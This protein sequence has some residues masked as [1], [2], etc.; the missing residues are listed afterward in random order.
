M[1]DT[2]ADTGS[3]KG[4][5]FEKDTC[6]VCGFEKEHTHTLNKAEAKSAGCLQ[7][8]N[9]EYFTCDSCG[10]VFK[11]DGITETTAEAEVIPALGHSFTDYKSNND[12]TCTDDG[13]KTAKCDRCDV[14]DTVADAGSA[15]GHSFVDDTCSV[16]G[17][18]QEH[19][20]R[21]TKTEAVAA[22]C[23]QNGNQEYWYCADCDSV[24][25]DAEGRYLTNRKNVIIPATKG[26]TY[27]PA[28]EGCHVPGTAEYWYCV[29][30]EAVFA[31]AAGT[32]LTN[33]KNLETAPTCELVHMDAVEPCHNNG[34][35]EY[36]FCPKCEA[37]FADAE[38]RQLTNRMN[39]TVPAVE[40][41]LQHFEAV[42]P[43]KDKDGV[44]EHW[45]C[46][47]CDCYFT[48]AEGKYNVAYKSL[49]LPAIETPKTGDTVM[50]WV[51]LAAVSV[52]GM[53]CT[54]ALNKKK[55]GV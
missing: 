21:M 55:F 11:A 20:H 40:G 17:F 41:A 19:V 22:T 5:C 7:A 4:H 28:A 34:T 39:L 36:W 47:G 35:L 29:E 10:I 48:D 15:K 42:A 43:T 31:D 3:A 54:V 23:H 45:Y 6:T 8:G 26:L 14:T 53:A 1:T 32:V 33:R 2:V 27:V 44:Q 18:V 49:I 25:S 37:V 13:T 9:Y 24:F 46:E 51:V 12:A 52:M 30:C 16:C 38:G 50:V